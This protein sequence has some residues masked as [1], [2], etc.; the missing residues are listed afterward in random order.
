MV[1]DLFLFISVSSCLISEVQKVW[2]NEYIRSIFGVYLLEVA[3]IV[4][5]WSRYF[6]QEA[7]FY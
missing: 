7:Y 1:N 4:E 6:A 5:D 2:L 3:M